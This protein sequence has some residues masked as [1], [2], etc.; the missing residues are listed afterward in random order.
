MT[1]WNTEAVV[2]RLDPQGESDLWVQMLTP[3]QGRISALAK[4]AM[5]SKERFTGVFEL[6]QVIEAG[7]LT[8]PR[9]G[10]VMIEHASIMR[11]F[12]RFRQNPLR[13]ARACLLTEIAM[14]GAAPQEPAAEF[15]KALVQGLARL[16]SQPDN[17]RWAVVYAY[18][19]L[20]MLGYK[21]SLDCCVCCRGEGDGPEMTF[22]A[23]AGG[24]LCASCRDHE[25]ASGTDFPAGMEIRVSLDTARTLTEIMRL[26]EARLPRI[27]FTRNALA[28]S[29]EILDPFIAYH[30]HRRSNAL[31]FM[32]K[33]AGNPAPGPSRD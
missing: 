22:N 9:S 5:R 8:A 24:I 4:G 29:M 11:Q 19:L 12:P 21:P 2:L 26:P 6:A 7:L 17:G 10:R 31:V 20:S 1:Q 33:M 16:H 25:R 28:Q 32:T 15:Y 18:R 14:L 30:L 13:L 23:A 3:G 27:S